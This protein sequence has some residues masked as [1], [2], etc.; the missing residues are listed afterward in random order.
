MINWDFTNMNS[1]FIDELKEEGEVV[2]VCYE[3]D[4]ENNT[5]F[6]M[7]IKKDLEKENFIMSFTFEEDEENEGQGEVV[8]SCYEECD[9]DSDDDENTKT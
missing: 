4:Y 6:L 2:I 9:T 1:N 5:G 7:D 3:E 8:I